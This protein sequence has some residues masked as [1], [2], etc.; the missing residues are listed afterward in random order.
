MISRVIPPTTTTISSLALSPLLS[1]SFTPSPPFIC[2]CRHPTAADP[3][4]CRIS[5][6]HPHSIAISSHS[7]ATRYFCYFQSL[8][9]ASTPAHTPATCTAPPITTERQPR[10]ALP[11]VSCNLVVH[12]ASSPIHPRKPLPASH[13][14][15]LLCIQQASSQQLRLL[16]LASCTDIDLPPPT[17]QL[18]ESSNLLIDSQTVYMQNELTSNLLPQLTW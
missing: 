14:S 3:L 10:P 6:S 13:E 5:L 17:T 9:A 18:Y 8:N 7:F 15:R 2:D 1:A 4:L 16:P 11:A 12:T